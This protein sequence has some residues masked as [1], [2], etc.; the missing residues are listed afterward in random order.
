MTSFYRCVKDVT[1]LNS[2]VMIGPFRN[3]IFMELKSAICYL[4]K[5]N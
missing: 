4:T 2:Y 3:L 1:Y 5:F